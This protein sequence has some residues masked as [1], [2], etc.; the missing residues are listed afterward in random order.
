MAPLQA[1]AVTNIGPNGPQDTVLQRESSPLQ[2]GRVQS[3]I[4]GPIPRATS[5]T[6]QTQQEG[7][8][9]P[10]LQ[11]LP[12]PAVATAPNPSPPRL[13]N[14]Q[15]ASIVNPGNLSPIGKVILSYHLMT[16]TWQLPSKLPR[17]LWQI[18]LDL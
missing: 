4:P 8:Q 14:T 17:K 16:I 9:P 11:V 10:Q 18:Q 3:P 1:A 2:D 13:N 12:T 7:D 5:T 15:M 6:L